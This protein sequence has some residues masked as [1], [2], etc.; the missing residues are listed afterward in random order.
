MKRLRATTKRSAHC[1][2]GTTRMPEEIR[3]PKIVDKQRFSGPS[4]D[5]GTERSG[6]AV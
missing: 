4:A 1:W 3:T 2:P 6:K 5:E